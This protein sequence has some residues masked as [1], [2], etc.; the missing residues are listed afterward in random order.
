M[1]LLILAPGVHVNESIF[2]RKNHVILDCFMKNLHLEL[3]NQQ[4]C[5]IKNE[6]LDCETIFS[7]VSVTWA[8]VKDSRM[9]QGS[10]VTMKLHC[11]V[12][13]YVTFVVT[14]IRALEGAFESLLSIPWW[15]TF[16]TL[17]HQSE[18]QP[19]SVWPVYSLEPRTQVSVWLESYRYI[20]RCQLEGKKIVRTCWAT[21]TRWWRNRRLITRKFYFVRILLKL[22]RLLGWNFSLLKREK[23]EPYY[24]VKS[25]FTKNNFSTIVQVP[26]ERKKTLNF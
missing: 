17:S 26:T 7:F 14:P 8:T 11:L 9:C 19:I 24:F 5:K 13:S 20:F 25:C 1:F 16:Q 10:N 12:C 15:V 6:K 23:H 21:I 2:N 18:F 4:I 22:R 3:L